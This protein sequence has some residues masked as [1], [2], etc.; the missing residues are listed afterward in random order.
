MFI[1]KKI[2]NIFLKINKIYISEVSAWVKN[3]S[4]LENGLF[5]QH[6]QNYSFSYKSYIILKLSRTNE[7]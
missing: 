7:N 2:D 4:Y 3:I 1:K 6:L 5:I